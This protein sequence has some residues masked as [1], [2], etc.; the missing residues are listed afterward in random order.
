MATKAELLDIARQALDEGDEATAN[1]A[2]DMIEKMQTVSSSDIPVGDA[3]KTYTDSQPVEESPITQ[4]VNALNQFAAAGVRGAVNTVDLLGSPFRAVL[5]GGTDILNKGVGL[6]T[7]KEYAPTEVPTLRESL[8]PYG[9]EANFME[10]GATRKIVEAGGQAVAPSAAVGGILRGV[11]KTVPYAA[12]GAEGLLKGAALQV[13]KGTS[14]A[15]DASL[16]ALSGF[17]AGAGQEVAGDPGALAGG[18]LSPVAGVAAAK[19]IKGAASAITAPKEAPLSE[20]DK[21]IQK[22]LQD[23][24]TGAGMSAKQVAGK[25]RRMGDEGMLADVDETFVSLLRTSVNENQNVRGFAKT[26]LINRQKGQAARI[27][28]KLGEET[29]T[30]GLTLDQEVDRVNNL[31][32]PKISK[33]YEEAGKVDF[34]LSQ[35]L[36]NMMSGGTS[37]N[38]A[39][40]NAQKAIKDIESIG[41]PVTQMTII[42]QT[43]KSLDD[44]ISKAYRKGANEE[45]SRLVKLKRVMLDEVDAANPI[46][47]KARALAADKKSL[48]N[49]ADLGLMFSKMKA[50]ELDELVSTMGASERHMYMLGAKQALL[51][52]IDNIGQNRDLVNALFGKNGDVRKLKTLFKKESKF[53]KF[54]NTLKMEADWRITSNAVRGGSQTKQFIDDSANAVQAVDSAVQFASSPVAAARISGNLLAKLKSKRNEESYKQALEKVGFILS[55]R[56]VE[57]KKVYELL[58]SGDEKRI[59]YFL[60]AMAPKT[61]VGEA[62]TPSLIGIQ[63]ETQQ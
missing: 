41:E 14:V 2:M 17:G 7:G 5:E 47:A 53:K 19:G 12:Q 50:S 1:A 63:T 25:V 18:I 22:L 10:D 9:I 16:G 52:R 57:P 24:A 20:S 44:M 35:K 38:V 39:Y 4:S 61:G 46:Y 56:G 58:K 15:S 3:Q 43:K 27:S 34:Q 59:K 48:Q 26:E 29:G 55:Q 21:I 37:L 33:L 51:D 8:S 40:K 31:L 11:S 32:Q 30:V 60:D 13:S 49:A 36:K 42:D 28:D 62:I 45:G 23:A 6:V 54:S